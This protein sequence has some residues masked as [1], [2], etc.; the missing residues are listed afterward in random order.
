MVV[1][2][3]EIKPANKTRDLEPAAFDVAAIV[4][5]EEY[6]FR[7]CIDFAQIGDQTIQCANLCDD[8]AE[9]LFR[10]HQILPV[11]ICRLVLSVY[12]GHSVE[13]PARLD[14]T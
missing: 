4:D 1:R 6:T 11:K 14:E 13:L 9:R 5:S 7:S 2:V 3:L 12:N 8:Q 10:W